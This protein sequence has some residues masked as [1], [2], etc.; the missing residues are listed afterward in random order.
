M[1]G[2]RAIQIAKEAIEGGAVLHELV[3]VVL[4]TVIN[5]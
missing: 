2:H 4:E 5:P 1:D 3:F